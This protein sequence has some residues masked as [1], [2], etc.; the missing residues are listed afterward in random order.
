VSLSLSQP[1]LRVLL[2]HLL[3]IK[4]EPIDLIP[5]LSL[6]VSLY[7]SLS[8]LSLDS[9]PGLHFAEAYVPPPLRYPDLY[10]ALYAIFG[11][12]LLWYY[13]YFL[14]WIASDS[15]RDSSGEGRS[16]KKTL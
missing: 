15:S 2:H 3:A 4:Q 10:P 9:P 6:S 14:A 13:V 1:L 7:L 5:S 8:L 12:N 11:C 16:E